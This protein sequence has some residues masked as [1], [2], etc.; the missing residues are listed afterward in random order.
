MYNFYK[1]ALAVHNAHRTLPAPHHTHPRSAACA[2]YAPQSYN[3]T[4]HSGRQRCYTVAHFTLQL[5]PAIVPE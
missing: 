1:P 4:V 5:R 3:P 2:I